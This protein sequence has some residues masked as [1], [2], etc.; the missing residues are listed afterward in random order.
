MLPTGTPRPSTA[1]KWSSKLDE[2]PPQALTRI[3]KKA[4]NDLKE[5]ALRGALARVCVQAGNVLLRVGSL[6]VLARLL[7]P[8]DFG[9]VGM[10]TAFTGLLNLFRD[11]GLSAAT[12]QRV[13]V[14]KEQTATLFWINLLVGASLTLLPIA[15]FTCSPKSCARA[16]RS[17]VISIISSL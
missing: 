4:M 8:S 16:G 12:V 11:F 14:T 6:V 7:S 15:I 1:A 17:E 3:I 9:L 2:C 5:K 13:T 10:V